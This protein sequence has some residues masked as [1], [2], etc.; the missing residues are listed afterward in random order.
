MKNVAWQ[1]FSII[2]EASQNEIADVVFPHVLHCFPMVFPSTFCVVHVR[3]LC[4]C[5][6]CVVQHAIIQQTLRSS[7]DQT[8]TPSERERER[9]T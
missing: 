1:C 6:L 3:A 7:T 8:T 4:D 2:L 9:E 5:A